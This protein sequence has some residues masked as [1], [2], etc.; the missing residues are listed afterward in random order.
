MQ[1]RVGVA[2]DSEQMTTLGVDGIVQTRT[3]GAAMQAISEEQKHGM[4]DGA[5][6]GGGPERESERK[7]S[8]DDQW[9]RIKGLKHR[10]SLAPVPRLISR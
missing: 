1:C 7:W 9:N 2:K 8:V 3:E 5:Q 4:M 6:G 10:E